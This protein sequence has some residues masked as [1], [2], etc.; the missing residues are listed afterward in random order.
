MNTV[1][2]DAL[3]RH[4]TFEVRVRLELSAGE[5][6]ALVGPIGAGKS[7]ALSLI[8][9][10]IGATAGQVHGP[11]RVWDDPATG[12]WVPPAERSVSHLRQRPTLIDD[13]AAIDQVKATTTGNARAILAELDLAEGV[14]VR[15]GWTLS[16][17]EVQ[18]VALAA[19]VAVP[20][21]VVLLDDPFAALDARTGALVRAW[22]AERLARRVH[23]TILACSDPEDAA[24]LA[25]WVVYLG[26]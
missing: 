6:V 2:V 16:G 15:D 20:A 19:A 22:L 1:A 4:D 3:V 23:S 7:T 14:Y 24:R 18:R 21:M 25:D 11:D 10:I 8:S 13:V 17:G 5:T 26:G 12:I 9:G